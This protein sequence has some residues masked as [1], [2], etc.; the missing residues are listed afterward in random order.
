VH[1]PIL[2]TPRQQLWGGVHFDRRQ[3]T[4]YLDGSRF[5]FVPGPENGRAKVNVLRFVGDW[6]W[7]SPKDVVAA[8]STVSWGRSSPGST[9]QP[10]GIPDGRFVA[11]LAQAQW[12]HLFSLPLA[13]T[14]LVV[15]GDLQLAND[16]LLTMEQIAVGGSRTV[17][18]YREN[19]LVRDQAVIGS[20]ELRVPVLSDLLGP[21][22]LMLA[23]F[24]DVGHAWNRKGTPSKET[25]EGVGVG[26][27]YAFSDRIQAR[28]YW[29][30]ALRDAPTRDNNIQ[31]NG[32]HLELEVRAF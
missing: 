13:G 22:V 8:R 9:K 19:L 14:Q 4:T 6:T 24:F 23:T 7:A 31:D 5:S 11:W 29:A 17:R 25:I 18:G 2:R 1:H 3:S 21:H 10:S 26:L 27:R 20:V 15:R 32:F 16:P 30:Y 12:A 28:A